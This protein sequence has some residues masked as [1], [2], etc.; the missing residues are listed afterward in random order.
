MKLS[1]RDIEDIRRRYKAGTS[2]QRELAELYG[3]SGTSINRAINGQR[4]EIKRK[5]RTKH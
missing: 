2:S 5:V 3:V 4:V 1:S